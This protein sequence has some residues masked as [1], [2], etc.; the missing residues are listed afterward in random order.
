MKR[1]VLSLI[2]GIGLSC[3]VACA[4]K[5][6]VAE[7]VEQEVVETT[8]GTEDVA[9][10]TQE[11][12]EVVGEESNEPEMETIYLLEKTTMYYEEE[13]EGT[14]ERSYNEA[15]KLMVDV[16]KDAGGNVLN[17]TEYEYDE[18]G[19]EIKRYQ[20]SEDG[21]Y[22]SQ[23]EK[24][25]DESGKVIKE[26][27]SNSYSEGTSTIAYEYDEKDLLKKT[28]TYDSNGKENK[29]S[30]YDKYGELILERHINSGE[31]Y[32]MDSEYDENG[33]LLKGDMYLNDSL[34]NSMEFEYD[35]NGN[36][37]KSKDTT[38]YQGEVSHSESILEYD[39]NGN[40]ILKIGY[41]EDGTISFRHIYEYIS[42][43]VEKSE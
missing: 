39:E 10:T 7:N 5:T 31:L 32:T 21:S 4:P 34:M 14:I 33:N 16:Q 42:M 38:Y 35:E 2:L 18:E 17:K 15:G 26:I 20:S 8:E 13:F 9:E 36:M 25:Y 22:W 28:I 12:E 27:S 29:I 37:I 24:E 6:E 19:N 11:S 43:E 41:N 3:L 1:K 40:M 23:S 30:E